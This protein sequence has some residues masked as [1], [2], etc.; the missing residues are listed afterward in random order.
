MNALWST[1]A[2]Y[3]AW[4]VQWK[5][6]YGQLTKDSRLAKA[7]RKVGSPEAKSLAQS[8]TQSLRNRAR[9][10]LETRREQKVLSW[11]QKQQ[12]VTA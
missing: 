9:T 8:L 3:L 4:V 6:Q 12:A 5:T 11:A 1:K 7:S 2:E 10:Q